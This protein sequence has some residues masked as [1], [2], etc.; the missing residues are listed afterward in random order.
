M[1]HQLQTL[2]GMLR[3]LGN[4]HMLETMQFT[5]C[6]GGGA[7]RMALKDLCMGLV[8]LFARCYLKTGENSWVACISGEKAMHSDL[9][10]LLYTA[11]RSQDWPESNISDLQELKLV[12]DDRNLVP[13]HIMKTDWELNE[14]CVKSTK[15]QWMG[16]SEEWVKE[17]LEY[18][19]E[20][21]NLE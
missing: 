20:V 2:K 7:N 13:Y 1:C 8:A 11:L 17:L 5:A 19:F 16:V 12:I 18:A 9:L 14:Y 4:P 10:T 21:S 6:N 3:F 15:R